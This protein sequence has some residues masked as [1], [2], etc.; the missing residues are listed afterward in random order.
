MSALWWL[1]PK[2]AKGYQNPLPSSTR[3]PTRPF[4]TAVTPSMRDV[5][6]TQRCATLAMVAVQWPE[7]ICN[8]PFFAFPSTVVLPG[9]LC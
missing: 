6:H 8:H 3:S 5:F 7:F 4:L 1:V 9:I 2:V